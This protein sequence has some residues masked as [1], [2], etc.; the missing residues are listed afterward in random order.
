MNL[1]ERFSKELNWLDKLDQ[2]TED[3]Q[4]AFAK[5]QSYAI[6]SYGRQIMKAQ[7]TRKLVYELNNMIDSIQDWSL[8]QILTEIETYIKGL[9]KQLLFAE[10]E[11]NSTNPISDVRNQQKASAKAQYIKDMTRLIKQARQD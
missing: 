9:E 1:K 10:W 4:T 11:A 7:T 6:E 5:D 8:D 3:F 2:V